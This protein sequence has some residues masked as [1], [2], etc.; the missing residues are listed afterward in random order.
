MA[1]RL[2]RKVVEVSGSGMAEVTFELPADVP[3]NLVSFAAFIGK[4]YPGSLQHLQSDLIPVNE[5]QP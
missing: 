3:D 1:K 5:A 4:D 2:D